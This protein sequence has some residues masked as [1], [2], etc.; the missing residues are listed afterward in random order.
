[1][2]NELPP[3]LKGYIDAVNRHDV[4]AMLL[5][6]SKTATVKDE[7]KTYTGHA[8]I[9]A[10]KE[11]TTRKYRVTVEVSDVA[12]TGNTFRIAMLVTGNFPG[13]PATL[14]YVFALKGG[15]IAWLEVS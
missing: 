2:T 1:M 14:H 4:D 15:L 13:S 9:R 7:G 6:F 12:R 11:E 3:S 8:D 5:A 10:W